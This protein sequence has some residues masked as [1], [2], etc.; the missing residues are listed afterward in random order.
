MVELDQN[1]HQ[2]I[3][4]YVDLLDTVSQGF[5]YVEE[6]YR[7]GDMQSADG[8]LSDTFLAFTQFETAN[9]TLFE[10]FNGEERIVQEIQSFYTLM[11]FSVNLKYD[12]TMR[13]PD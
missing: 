8:V 4:N 3:R 12:L 1:Q 10:I 9:H 13:M 6:Q 7:K 11:S 5:Q 2:L